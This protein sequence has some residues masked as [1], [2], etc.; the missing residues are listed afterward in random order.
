MTQQMFTVM[1]MRCRG[2][3]DTMRQ[4]LLTL[5]GLSP[6]EVTLGTAAQSIIT[7]HADH[8]LDPDRVRA[9]LRSRGDFLVQR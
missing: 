9:A 3:A 8:P 4:A 6:V 7:V 1:G 5:D 2:C